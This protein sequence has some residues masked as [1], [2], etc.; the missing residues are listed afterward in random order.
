MSSSLVVH[1]H[2]HARYTGATRHV[3]SV[4]PALAQQVDARVIGDV[5]DSALPRIG[6]GELL[7]HRGPI[8]WH[9]HRVNELLVG[10]C[11]RLFKRHL[12]VV[13]TRHSTGRPAGFTAFLARRADRVVSVSPETAETLGLPSTVVTHG[14]DLARFA[15]PPD[16]AQAWAA[17][18]LGGKYGVGVIGRVRHDKGQGD[19]AQALRPL[20]EQ[21]PDWRAALV[22]L[23]KPAE[24]SWAQSLGL[25]LA[26]E[27]PD[28][29]RW[30]RGFTILVMP[31]HDESFG[32]VRAEALAAGCCLVT[33]R[34]NALDR[35]LEHG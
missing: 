2:F 5:R 4:L 29:E 18:G 9:A 1:P 16:R 14:V 21:H 35:M 3:E 7:R 32:L 17:L 24:A 13:W 31:S 22:G 8:V 23:V 25:H 33:T 11:L 19:F 27:S 34:L 15:A 10:L 28:V 20:L 6:W 30:Y 26:G 12:R